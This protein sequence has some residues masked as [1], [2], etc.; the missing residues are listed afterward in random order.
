MQKLYGTNTV[1]CTVRLC[2]SRPINYS[3]A[4]RAMYYLQ[5]FSKLV[6]TLVVLGHPWTYVKVYKQKYHTFFAATQFNPHIA[7]H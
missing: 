6:G 3:D 5:L 7:E 1:H 4:I 2:K